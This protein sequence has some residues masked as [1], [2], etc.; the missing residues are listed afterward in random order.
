MKDDRLLDGVKVVVVP[1]EDTVPLI[2]PLPSLTLNVPVVMVEASIDS[3]NVAEIALFIAT[4]EAPLAGFV[5]MTVGG[6]FSAVVKLQV[7]SLSSVVPAAFAA[8]APVV[9]VAVYVVL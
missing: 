6:E 3:L 4:L 2:L 1:L 5:E 7:L 8:C 9:I